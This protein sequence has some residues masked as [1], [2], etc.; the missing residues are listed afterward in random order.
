MSRRKIAVVL[1][2]LGGPDGPDAVR[3]FLFNLFNDP[4][5]IGLPWP[6]RTLLAR[7]ISTTRTKSA[8]ANYNLMG[9]GSPLLPE[10]KKQSAALQAALTGRL[11]DADVQCF[12]AMRYWKP[13]VEETAA[14]VKRC[15]PDEVVL[16]PL[17][18]QFSTTTTASSFKAWRRAYD[19]PAKAV[20]C[21][22]QAA[23]FAE[24][25]AQSIRETAAGRDPA[26][27]GCCSPPTACRRRWSPAAIP[28]RRRWRAPS[29]P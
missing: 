24:A 13:F 22:P 4:A 16:L 12:I 18:P 7:L 19:G 21:Y 8:Q 28:T 26:P 6:A 27:C 3:P 25:Y 15:A 23:G 20:C 1:F 2:N 11:A 10:T 29:A 14:E 5:I 9:G 17:Y